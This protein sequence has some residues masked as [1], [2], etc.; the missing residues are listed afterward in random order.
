MC[1]NVEFDLHN[2]LSKQTVKEILTRLHEDDAVSQIKANY[3]VNKITS[4]R[5]K[6]AQ[7]RFSLTPKDLLVEAVY[8][9]FEGET[10]DQHIAQINSTYDFD[11]YS[12]LMSNV[13]TEFAV[14]HNAILTALPYYEKAGF[15]E[16][17]HVGN[18]TYFSIDEEL[19]QLIEEYDYVK[20][21]HLDKD[22]ELYELQ[23]PLRLKYLSFGKYD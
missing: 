17:R 21:D 5:N 1:Y 14:E 15:G 3:M 11:E 22:N 9:C 4:S 20:V 2:Y 19:K 6:Q 18:S 16:L 23:L 8:T 7:Y 12:I 13:V 10:L